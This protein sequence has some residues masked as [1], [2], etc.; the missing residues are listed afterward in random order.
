MN[1]GTI[2]GVVRFNFE[3]DLK[4]EDLKYDIAIIGGGAGGLAA[5]VCISKKL[6]KN[7]KKYKIVVIEKEQK[8]GRKLLATG[9]GKCNLTNENMSP[10]YYN[11]SSR[12]F[13]SPI[14][15][16]YKTDKLTSFF[17]SLGMIFRSDSAGRV[18][19]Y[20]GMSADVLNTLVMNVE[21]YG[22]DIHC[23]VNI[24]K[25]EKQSTGFKLSAGKVSY[26]C[27]KLI[28]ASGGKAQPNL[29]SKGA[30]YGF[31]KMLGLDV[32]A[33]YP[34]LAPIPCGDNDL[35]LVKGVRVPCCVTLKADGKTIHTE[36]GELQ[37]NEN[38]VS[39][40]CVFQLSRY[41]GEFF[42]LGTVSGEKADKILISA[43]LMPE[44]TQEDI[45]KYLEMQRRRYSAVKTEEIFTGMLNRKLG[46]FLCGRAGID[47]NEYM[48]SVSD[49]NIVRLAAVVKNCT[50]T[51]SAV[52]SFNTSQVT[53][54][55]IKV[56]QINNDMSCKKHSD[57]YIVGEA[58]DV[59]GMCGGYNLHFAFA[60]GIIAGNACA[61][62][63]K[64]GRK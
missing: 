32:A 23:G 30:S 57:L 54:G 35:A 33:V 5:A 43:D 8:C 3:K 22:T 17:S 56:S 39:G 29:G 38:N 25:I 21:M 16:K 61:D 53:A 12:E 40:I 34:A 49:D 20:S 24:D 10:E 31:A 2:S 36:K 26:V 64:G 4:M 50:F 45:E 13:I 48:Y 18:Y 62:K 44:Y 63:L 11:K 58:L 51:P 60:S 46:M 28:I 47:T 27:K 41:A 1:F 37:L 6:N 7:G 19:P 52:P 42:T 59:D 55:G 15:S 14:L 9:N